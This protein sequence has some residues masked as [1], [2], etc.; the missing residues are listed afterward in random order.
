MKIVANSDSIAQDHSFEIETYNERRKKLKLGTTETGIVLFES[1]VGIGLFTLHYPLHQAGI[2]WGFFLNILIYFI[3]AYG[4]T[5]YHKVANFVE[6]EEESEDEDGVRIR[7]V[8]DLIKKVGGRKAKILKYFLVLAALGMMNSSSIGN[9]ALTSKM[10]FL[11]KF[12]KKNFYEENIFIYD[13]LAERL[14]KLVGVPTLVTKLGFFIINC[15]SIF[16]IVEPEKIRPFAIVSL[17]LIL[18]M[19]YSSF[20]DNIRLIFVKG[21]NWKNLRYFDFKKTGEFTGITAYAFEAA[22]SY[23]SSKEFF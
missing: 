11:G 15:F 3:T 20:F 6:E 19:G 12:V 18:G 9:L 7:T 17:I 1:A 10:F 8:E 2:I 16:F 4:L 14:K 22:G 21:V 5:L 13:S 23:M